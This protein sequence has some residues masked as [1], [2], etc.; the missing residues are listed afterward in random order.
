MYAVR[1]HE[2]GGP[3]KM[4]Y[5]AIERPAPGAG[6]ALVRIE[7]AGVNFVDTY[8]RAGIYSVPLPYTLG[9]EGGG[10]VEAVGVDVSA[11]SPGERVAFA[12]DHGSYAEYAAIPAWKLVPVP[13]DVTM[14]TA[15]AAQVQGMTAHYLTHST[16]PIQQG[17]TVLVHAAAGGTGQLVVQMAKRRGATVVGTVS[18]E[19]KAALARSLGADEVILY[20]EEDFEAAIKELTDGRGVDAVYDSVGQAT[21]EKSLNCLRP[22]GILVLF[23]ASSG[24]VPP[25]DPQVLNRKGSLYLTRPGLGSYMATPEEIRWRTGDLFDWLAAGELQIRIDAAFPLAEAA[26]AHRYLEGRQTK[27][28]IVLIPG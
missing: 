12:M 22:R 7:A 15:V 4:K 26:E 11:V 23:G 2:F 28:K 10:V 18:T 21:F 5:E 19:E 20:T 3:E 16:Y 8:Q 25:F 9:V 14:E 6:E 27:G 24:P 13:D 1:M 17:D